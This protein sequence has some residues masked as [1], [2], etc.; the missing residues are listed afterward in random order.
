MMRTLPCERVEQVMGIPESSPGSGGRTEK[1]V[2][3]RHL[4]NDFGKIIGILE[5][6]VPSSFPIDIAPKIY[7]K[8][9]VI[10]EDSNDFIQSIAF[11]HASK[12]YADPPVEPYRSTR[13]YDIAIGTV[14]GTSKHCRL[15]G[16]IA[17]LRQPRSYYRIENSTGLLGEIQ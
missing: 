13:Y 7:Q 4:A 5:P 14:S 12:L 10:P 9:V 1:S 11:A 15:T 17:Q 2:V 3:Q 16:P 8:A 6:D